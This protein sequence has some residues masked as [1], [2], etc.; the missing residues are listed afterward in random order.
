MSF[1][2]APCL[3]HSLA[4]LLMAFRSRLSTSA[5]G[6]CRKKQH[7]WLWLQTGTGNDSRKIAPKRKHRNHPQKLPNANYTTCIKPGTPSSFSAYS[8]YCTSSP[9]RIGVLNLLPYFHITHGTRRQNVS[10]SRIQPSGLCDTMHCDAAL[11]CDSV[12]CGYVGYVRLWL[13]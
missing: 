13:L 1:A 8:I 12:W 7:L 4:G 9:V 3:E 10:A 2:F 5:N 6:T 11:R